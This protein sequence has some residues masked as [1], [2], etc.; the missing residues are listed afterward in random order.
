[1]SFLNLFALKL[2]RLGCRWFVANIMS[3]Y[4]VH[5]H[6]LGR[7]NFANYCGSDYVFILK[8]YYI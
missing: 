5:K 3:Y 4:D 6:L 2:T 1:M 8:D 7:K